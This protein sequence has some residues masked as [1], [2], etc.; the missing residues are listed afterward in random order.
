MV[1]QCGEVWIDEDQGM[2]FQKDWD[3]STDATPIKVIS[4]ASSTSV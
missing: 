1:I 4:K 2:V 3:E